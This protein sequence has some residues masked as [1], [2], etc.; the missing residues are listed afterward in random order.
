MKIFGLIV[1]IW[2]IFT[3]NSYFIG[4][5][6]K[7][8][9][10]YL[11]NVIC[12]AL[13][14]ISLFAIIQFA[15]LPLI[16]ITAINYQ[17]IGF[18][19]IAIQI[20]LIICYCINWRFSL[21][22]IKIKWQ[23]IVIF[24]S[25]IILIV[26]INLLF[27]NYQNVS[28]N[29]SINWDNS[30]F[31]FKNN[32]IDWT[33]SIFVKL[34]QLFLKLFNINN[35][36]INIQYVWI[37]PFS[38]FVT[39]LIYGVYCYNKENNWKDWKFWT[40]LIGSTLLLLIFSLS[41]Q[42]N[43]SKGYGWII[44]TLLIVWYLH[45]YNYYNGYDVKCT[46]LI[47]LVL[48]GLFFI[49]PSAIFIIITI[50]LYLIYDNYKKKIPFVWTYNSLFIINIIFCLGIFLYY[51]NIIIGCVISYL[52]VLA[53]IIW[54]NFNFFV[55]KNKTIKKIFSNNYQINQFLIP[56]PFLFFFIIL[57][58]VLAN[59]TQFNFQSWI[60][61]EFMNKSISNNNLVSY[62]MVNVCYWIF[63][64]LPL[65]FDLIYL[66]FKFLKK[67]IFNYKELNGLT[68]F[69]Y[70]FMFN[71]VVVEFLTISLNNSYLPIQILSNINALYFLKMFEPKRI[72]CKKTPVI[73]LFTSVV[74]SLI[75]GLTIFNFVG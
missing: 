51:H 63:I 34:A 50:A 3:F 19:L 28:D 47:N 31:L 60:I 61:T 24:L 65:V 11:N 6:I 36:A 67:Q 73:I 53:L 41:Y 15:F 7:Y 30:F 8:Y 66:I 55:N 25:F 27:A 62:W 13:G 56:V 10:R 33:N 69:N 1:I 59:K 45:Q 68:S 17:F 46:Y 22:K 72:Y 35:F 40:V 9:N 74:T 26:T 2:L 16:L 75:I 44:P 14:S 5:I 38:C 52:T 32:N 57:I 54:K 49:I 58:I 39:S 42:T 20:I 21:M 70:I 64:S 43:L 12:F 23:T 48:L 29:L 4:K 18:Y 37:L 71:P